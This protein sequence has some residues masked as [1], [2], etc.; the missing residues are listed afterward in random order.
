M[1]AGKNNFLFYTD[2]DD[3]VTESAPALAGT[4]AAFATEFG[5][6][7]NVWQQ[8]LTYILMTHDNAFTLACERR[9][10][11]PDSTLL[12]LAERDLSIFMELFGT[13]EEDFD[14]DERLLPLML[15]YKAPYESECIT[16]AGCRIKELSRRLAGAEDVKE[17]A[18]TLTEY[19]EKYGAGMFGLYKAFRVDPSSGGAAEL[20][21]VPVTDSADVRFD[22]LIGY[23]SQKKTLRD[24]T[25]AF[26]SG[27]Y[28]NNVLLYGD[29]GTGK[30]TSVHALMHEYSDRGLRLIEVSKTDRGRIPQILSA[31]KKRNYRFILFLD[32]L[33]FEEDESDYKELKAMLEGAL[34]TRSDKV[35][36]YA[37]SNRRHLI[38]ETW[39]DRSDMEYNEDVHRS[40]TMEE[41]LSLAGRFGVM[42]YYPKPGQKEYLEIVR[43]LAARKGIELKGQELEDAARKWELRHGGMSGRT[44]SQLITW[45][46]GTEE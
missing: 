29:S 46:D 8:W 19:Y 14:E 15:D 23:E 24:N 1:K 44:A 12:K 10:I 22:D 4:L 5:L 37:T 21:L 32:D 39:G 16:E 9:Y 35:L 26:V 17:F 36:I 33:S 41:K 42:I 18:R 13:K 3:R 31:I 38:R 2:W 30:S 11:I 6:S 20:K 43:S 28:A 45:L 34:E 7:G 40:D 25:E 27:H